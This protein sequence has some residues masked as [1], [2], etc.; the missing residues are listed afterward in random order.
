MLEPTVS[1]R[2][3]HLLN[4]QHHPTNEFT[5]LANQRTQL[6]NKK[7][8]QPC[9]LQCSQWVLQNTNQITQWIDG[10]METISYLSHPINPSRMEQL[11]S[12]ELYIRMHSANPSQ[13]QWPGHACKQR[14]VYAS[15]QHADTFN[16]L[17]S[18]LNAY[19]VGKKNVL[20]AK[21]RGVKLRHYYESLSAI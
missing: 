6:T 2:H 10:I 16:E 5:Q 1:Q 7:W 15:N 21:L 12:R 3:I 9:K 20:A 17:A 19:A 14:I 4:R 18:D 11:Y 8:I 13:L